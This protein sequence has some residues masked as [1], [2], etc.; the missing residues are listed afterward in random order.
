MA[1]EPYSTHKETTAFREGTQHHH[2]GDDEK[3][4][5]KESSLKEMTMNIYHGY[6]VFVATFFLN[7]VTIGQFNS[8]R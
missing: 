3:K 1:I 4:A 7:F 8:S 2:V 5:W 6:Y